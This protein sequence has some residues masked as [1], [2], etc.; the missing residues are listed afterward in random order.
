MSTASQQVQRSVAVRNQR[1]ESKVVEPSFSRVQPCASRSESAEQGRRKKDAYFFGNNGHTPATLLMPGG[2]LCGRSIGIAAV[3]A[4][5]MHRG[6]WTPSLALE[7]S[8]IL[9]QDPEGNMAA[10]GIVSTL[11]LVGNSAIGETG[12]RTGGRF[13]SFKTHQ[14]CRALLLLS[15]LY[16]Y[17]AWHIFCQLERAPPLYPSFQLAP[18]APITLSGLKSVDREKWELEKE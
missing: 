6:W 1:K 2:D 18:L 10:V 17:C 5:W 7:Y 9:A 13:R 3:D 16:N 4:S 14:F 15:L 8:S 12:K 11:D